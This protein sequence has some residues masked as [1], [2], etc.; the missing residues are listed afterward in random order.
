[1][2]GTVIGLIDIYGPA[3]LIIMVMNMTITLAWLLADRGHW[4]M[5][6]YVPVALF[7]L[8]GVYSSLNNGL[9]SLLMGYII[10]IVLAAFLLGNRKQ[11]ILVGISTVA[12]LGLG[13]Q[14]DRS[15][16][17]VA[18]PDFIV[19]GTTFTGIALL[20]SLALE[21]LHRA[22]ANSRTFA[23]SLQTEITE[24]KRVEEAL[25]KSEEKYRMLVENQGEGVV[26]V[27]PE[28]EFTFVNPAAESLFGVPNLVGRN[29]REFTSTDQYHQI[30]EQTRIRQTGEKSS[31]EIEILRPDGERLILL[32]TATPLFENGG[33]FTGAFGVL[34]D[35]TARK[36][37]EAELARYAQGMVALNDTILE[38]NAQTDLPTL[39]QAI[40]KRAAGLMETPRAALYLMGPGGNSLELVINQPLEDLHTMLRLGEGLAGQVAQAGEPIIVRD[41][42]QWEGRLPIHFMAENTTVGRALGIP[43]KLGGKV[44]GVLTFQDFHPGYFDEDEVRLV[45]LFADQAA[46]AIEK[47]RLYA[48]VQRLATVDEVTGLLNRRGLWEFGRREFE[49]SRRFSRPLAVIFLDIDHFKQVNDTYGH[50]IGDQV[51]R[52]LCD[53]LRANTREVD[54]VARYGGEEFVILLPEVETPLATQVAE[55]LRRSMAEA[56]AVTDQ[57]PVKV[58]ISLGVVQMR[59]EIHDLATLIDLADQAMFAAKQN[60]R[61]RVEVLQEALDH[62]R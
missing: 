14:H 44:I 21:Q 43:L 58:S 20:Q 59:N 60:G 40:V 29:L 26:F 50:A 46:L 11:W 30:R 12:H 13:W 24:R 3:I 22:L 36:R 1:L 55:R 41:Y 16:L 9:V 53:R 47:A 8:L 45:S 15:T 34:R 54:V 5:T 42:S 17:N 37:A 27:D 48:E 62:K 35:I 10:A 49:R 31:Y 2:S 52:T 25:K 39:L 18:I 23:K 33:K 19:V 28:E 57:G 51:L 38:I 7:F 32:A 4:R 56:P 61:N 6:R